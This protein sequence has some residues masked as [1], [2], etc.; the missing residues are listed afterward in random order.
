MSQ[1]ESAKVSL[2][3]FFVKRSC[4]LRAGALECKSVSLA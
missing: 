1:G 4:H 3:G 2:F